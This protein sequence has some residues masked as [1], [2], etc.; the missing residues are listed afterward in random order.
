MARRTF[1]PFDMGM[2]KNEG[3]KNPPT[4]TGSSP[5]KISRKTWGVLTHTHLMK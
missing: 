2:F 4:K 3:L 5:K 1:V